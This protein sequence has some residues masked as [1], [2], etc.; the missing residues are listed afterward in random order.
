M[1]VIAFATL[2]AAAVGAQASRPPSA[3][4]T[5]ATFFEQSEDTEVWDPIEEPVVEP[6]EAYTEGVHCLYAYFSLLLPPGE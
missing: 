1:R 3:G 2:A 4:R 6:S 5:L